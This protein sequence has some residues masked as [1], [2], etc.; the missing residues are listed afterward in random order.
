MAKKNANL[1]VR[2]SSETKRAVKNLAAHYELSIGKFVRT[3]LD[4]E[5][6]NIK[7]ADYFQK[8]LRR[9]KR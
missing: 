8:K 1:V 6:N 2:V 7:P 9:K 4:K 3:L 5:L